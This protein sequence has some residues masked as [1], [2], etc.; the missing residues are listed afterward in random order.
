MS[1]LGAVTGN[2]PLDAGKLIISDFFN[3]KTYRE[4][5]REES[6]NSLALWKKK[7]SLKAI[8]SPSLFTGEGEAVTQHAGTDVII[9]LSVMWWKNHS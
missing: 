6:T 1:V 3:N 5:K 7:L 9:Y 4:R 8:F 2:I